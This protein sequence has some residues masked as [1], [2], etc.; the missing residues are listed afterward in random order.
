M[1]WLAGYSP[2][3]PTNLGISK[4]SLVGIFSQ[5][6]LCNMG[7]FINLVRSGILSDSKY[8]M[9]GVFP[10]MLCGRKQVF[11]NEIIILQ[12]VIPTRVAIWG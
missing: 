4:G 5:V 6:G 3:L 8:G 11:Y 10:S 2:G 1:M 9:A 7:Q 12:S